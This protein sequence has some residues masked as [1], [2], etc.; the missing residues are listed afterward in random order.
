[1][2]ES[3][4][5]IELVGEGF[6]VDVRSVHVAIEL[7]AW[8]RAD[9][10]RGHRYRSNALLGQARATSIAYSWKITGSL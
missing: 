3:R 6:E 1:M 8:F 10:T 7:G 5:A 2:A 9:L 4:L